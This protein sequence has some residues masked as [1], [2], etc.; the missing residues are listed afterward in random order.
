MLTNEYLYAT[1]YRSQSIV[2]LRHNAQKILRS[3]SQTGNPPSVIGK[4]TVN[5]V[6]IFNLLSTDIEPL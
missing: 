6:P 2:N 1:L 4:T 3:Q 5:L